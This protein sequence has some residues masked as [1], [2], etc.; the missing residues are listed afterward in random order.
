MQPEA[1]VIVTQCVPASSETAVIVVS[2]LSQRTVYP[3]V[4]PVAETAAEP[5]FP[6]GQETI[7]GLLC[8]F[9]SFILHRVTPLSSGTRTSLVTWL[10]G[11]NLR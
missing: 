7:K 5:S 4:P 10:C 11:A 2:P 1:S 9:P 6:L 8:F 3:G